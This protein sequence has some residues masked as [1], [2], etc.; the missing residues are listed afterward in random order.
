MIACGIFFLLLA[1]GVSG[2]RDRPRLTMTLFFAS[3]FAIALLF[4]HHA[5]SQLDI[6]L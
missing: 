3:W 2:F 1:T 4:M 5:T 6:N